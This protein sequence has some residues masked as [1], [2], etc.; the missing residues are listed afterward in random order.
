MAQ[1]CGPR[2]CWELLALLASLLLFWAEAAD[3]E[4]DVRAFCRVPKRVGSCRAS[5]RRW[6]YNATGRSCQQFVYGGCGGNDNNYLTEEKCLQTCAHVTGNTTDDL[7]TSGKG[8]DSSVPRVP[9]RQHVEGPRSDIFR[10]EEHCMARAVTGPCRSSL[11]RW[12]FDVQKNTCDNF[13]YGGCWGNKNNYLSKEACLRRCR[14]AGRQLY[15]A[16][17]CSATA[18]LE[19]LFLTVLVLLLGASAVYLLLV[20]RRSRESCPFICSLRG[21]EKPVLKKKGTWGRGGVTT[22]ECQCAV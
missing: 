11:P 9:R 17:P 22:E 10:Y 5:L 7:P 12:Y 1:L 16:L 6:W 4:R 19:G 15:S 14:A 2:R 8:A 18:V 20:A 21:A 13:I 3:R